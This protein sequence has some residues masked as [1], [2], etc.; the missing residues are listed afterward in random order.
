MHKVAVLVSGPVL[1]SGV[2][3]PEAGN[4]HTGRLVIA[5]KKAVIAVGVIVHEYTPVKSVQENSLKT[6]LNKEGR[7]DAVQVVLSTNVSLAGVQ[8]VASSLSLFSSYATMSYP[9]EEGLAKIN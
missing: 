5:L 6:V 8:Q 7:V 3:F 1:G 4:V 2:F 9:C